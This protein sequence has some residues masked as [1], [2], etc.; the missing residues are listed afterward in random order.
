MFHSFLK[1]SERLDKTLRLLNILIKRKNA[2]NNGYFYRPWRLNDF[3]NEI[4]I[5]FKLFNRIFLILKI[6]R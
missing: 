1:Y 3:T 4:L 6:C 5:D 2:F